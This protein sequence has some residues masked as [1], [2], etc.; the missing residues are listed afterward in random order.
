MYANV[1]GLSV[2]P[3]LRPSVMWSY[4]LCYFRKLAPFKPQNKIG[5]LSHRKHLQISSR[6]VAGWLF[7]A[8]SP[9]ISLK[10][11]KII[12][13]PVNGGPKFNITVFNNA[14]PLNTLY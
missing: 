13:N 2:R 6:I 10:W 8:D 5:N 9:A 4:D 12:G 3:S 1:D 11:D 7:L 14:C